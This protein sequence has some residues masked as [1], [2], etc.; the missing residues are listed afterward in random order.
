MKKLR[1]AKLCVFSLFLATSVLTISPAHADVPAGGP[2]PLG[3][4][5]A[6]NNAVVFYN[7][8][9]PVPV[10]TGKLM[11]V[12]T[13]DPTL[14]V[15]QAGAPV[16]TL[17]FTSSC[18]RVDIYRASD[19]YFASLPASGIVSSTFISFLASTA[20]GYGTLLANAGVVAGVTR[21]Q[22]VGSTSFWSNNPSVALVNFAPPVAPAFTLSKSSETAT[23]SSPISGYT[24]NET[25]GPRTYSISPAIRNTPGLSFD[26]S[27][28][29]ISG[30][31]TTAAS[32]RT[33][34][35]TATNGAGSSTA[36]YSI[37]VLGLPPTIGPSGDLLSLNTN[38][39][40][41]LATVLTHPLVITG[42][43]AG[44]TLRAILTASSGTLNATTATAGITAAVGYQATVTSA[45]ASIGLVGTMANLNTELATVQFNAPASGAS[46]TI[47]ISVTDSGAGG[48]AYNPANGRYYEYVSTPVTWVQAYN[49]ITGDTLVDETTIART[50]RSFASCPKSFNGMC[51]YFATV[52]SA[53]END[54]VTSKVGTAQ[55]WLGGSDRYQ[56]GKWVWSDPAAP[57]YNQQ[58]SDQRDGLGGIDQTGIDHYGTNKTSPN[59]TGQC[60]SYSSGGHTYCWA[61]WNDGEPNG[62]RGENA[63]Q[64]LSGAPPYNKW[65]DLSENGQTM[66]YVVEYG[67]N[68][69][70]V[71]YPDASRT[72]S[73]DL[74]VNYFV[75]SALSAP[76]S[77]LVTVGYTTGTSTAVT[78]TRG[79]NSG[80]NPTTTLSVSGGTWTLTTGTGTT[81]TATIVTSSAPAAITLTAP[82]GSYVLTL[83]AGSTPGTYTATDTSTTPLSY[84]VVINDINFFV[85]FASSLPTS[86]SV[87]TGYTNGTSTTVT[88]TRGGNTGSPPT[89]TLS[90]TGGTWT[91]TSGTGTTSSSSSV[92]SAAPATLTLTASSGTYTLS[93]D[94]GSSAGIYTAS[95][96]ATTSLSYAITV[97]TPPR[98]PSSSPPTNYQID[99]GILTPP[100][101]PTK[102]A[103]QTSSQRQ[104]PA[105]IN[106]PQLLQNSQLIPVSTLTPADVQ[107]LI[108]QNAIVI[109]PPKTKITYVYTP[110]YVKS[111]LTLTTGKTISLIIPAAKNVVVHTGFPNKQSA[112]IFSKSIAKPTRSYV[113]GFYFSKP[114][115][116]IFT[117]NIDQKTITMPIVVAQA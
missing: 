44:D 17:T 9:D 97:T 95:D 57:E 49:A 66:G 56:E 109:A 27:T 86:A 58:F 88:L 71:T 52:R 89:T 26:Q 13:Y 112:V 11:N 33:Y 87:N 30:T 22:F 108:D 40:T 1:L 81:S 90:V 73:V 103:A 53:E 104:T 116:Y 101:A 43:P 35:I 75:T 105:P 74:P 20:Y 28:G 65:N 82:T 59:G 70:T 38:S 102:G 15:F 6:G 85:S 113:Q 111:G 61:F 114:G 84:A 23:V 24:I 14:A 110:Q 12:L 98:P 60:T 7:S 79:G 115:R 16:S 4:L 62:S 93:L 78:L 96:T 69:E 72:I 47:S 25:G 107:T 8:A 31:P 106:I 76:T 100:T 29:L 94:A 48:A 2:Y 99:P 83:S 92:T 37:N 54:F 45:A 19:A 34:T 63:L 46:A 117:I 50:T 41:N 67:G 39:H 32:S 80:S 5:C 3:T 55:A 10:T 91:L 64:I 21:Y 18:A 68:A 77:A 42:F 51:G 36:T